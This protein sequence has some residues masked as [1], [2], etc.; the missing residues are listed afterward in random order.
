[1][2][3]NNLSSLVADTKRKN[4]LSLFSKNKRGFFLTMIALLLVSLFVIYL[5]ISIISQTSPQNAANAA[6]ATSITSFV[7]SMSDFYLQNILSVTL[8]SS[9]IGMNSYL[10]G[11]NAFVPA[12]NQRTAFYQLITNGT[13][14][15]YQNIVYSNETLNSLLPVFVSLVNAQLNIPLVLNY[16]PYQFTVTQDSPWTVTVRMVFLYSIN[17]TDVV[18]NNKTLEVYAT[19]PING[20]ADPYSLINTHG[21]YAPNISQT[22]VSTWTIALWKKHILSQQFAADSLAPSYLDRL[23]NVSSASPNGIEFFILPGQYGYNTT[24]VSYSFVDYQFWTRPWNCT[25]LEN[26]LLN[27]T[28]ISDVSPLQNFLADDAHTAKY[29][30]VNERIFNTT[31]VCS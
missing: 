27:I 22:N 8:R 23:A 10:A 3:I 12:Q 18:I 17:Q 14:Y 7:S 5:Q 24:P 30:T 19:V 4:T 16:T 31:L 1:M 28:G 11:N 25:A 21:A 9:L 2:A 6:L 20:L 29:T 15:P 13:M 26:N